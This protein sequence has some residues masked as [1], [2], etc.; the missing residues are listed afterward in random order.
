MFCSLDRACSLLQR[1]QPH[2]EHQ[3]AA[4]LASDE[5]SDRERGSGCPPSGKHWTSSLSADCSSHGRLAWSRISIA[6]TISAELPSV[7]GTGLP[8]VHLVVISSWPPGREFQ[9][10]TPR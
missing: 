3:L 7:T 10:E 1:T 4:D 8:V 6:A 9:T 2:R 5:W